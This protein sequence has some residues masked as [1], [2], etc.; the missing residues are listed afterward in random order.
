MRK[1][2]MLGF[3]I[4]S[5]ISIGLALLFWALPS[6]YFLDGIR[7]TTDSLWQIGKLMFFSIAIYTIIE[8]YIFGREFENFI[9][10]KAATLFIAPLIYIGASYILDVGLGAATVNNHIV[11]YALAV[12]VGQY[13]SFY[14][15]RD[16]YYFKLMNGYA[17]IG[18]LLMITIFITYGSTTDKFN[19]HIFQP[20]ER[21]KTSIKNLQ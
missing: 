12:F 15:L 5:L 16:G 9:F 21:Y 7:P 4:I 13:V 2:E 18:I 3:F 14:I 10:A 1:Y 20:M 19:S 8:Y 6:S 17:V 11:T